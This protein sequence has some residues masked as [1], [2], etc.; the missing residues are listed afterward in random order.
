MDEYKSFIKDGEI[1]YT[2]KIDSLKIF[3]GKN[4]VEIKGI[5]ISD[6]KVSELRAYWN[7]RKDSISFPI[8]R[9]NGVQEFSGVI[10][11]LEEN[12]YNFEVRTFSKLGN[13]SIAQ[14]QTVEV[15]GDRYQSSILDRPIVNTNLSIDGTLLINFAAM[16]ITMGIYATEVVYTDKF[17]LEHTVTVPVKDFQLSIANYKSGS[18]FKQRSLYLP[19][20][21]AIDVFYTEYQSIKPLSIPILINSQIPFQSTGSNR[22]TTTNFG[23]LDNWITN[24]AAKNTPGGFGGFQNSDGGVMELEAG[25]NGFPGVINGKIYQV[26]NADPQSY[27]LSVNASNTNFDNTMSVYIVVAKGGV[28]PDISNVTTDPN[29]LG[30]NKIT[31]QNVFRVNFTVAN[32]SDIC[33]GLV[34]NLPSSPGHWCYIKSWDITKNQ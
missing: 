6:P 14:F 4:R 24:D 17:N 22:S 34:Y 13:K 5:L 7:N 12:V 16:D 1:S 33:I 32:E 25:F 28:M 26:V 15:Y 11:N 20:P 27:R 21:T 19:V 18:S 23:T 29:V 30:Y 2:G 3:P 8:V 10:N 31:G 9:I